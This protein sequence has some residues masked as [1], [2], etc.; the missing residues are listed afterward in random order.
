MKFYT[1]LEQFEVVPVFTNGYFFFSNS[2]LYLI[3][4]TVLIVLTFLTAL[5]KVEIIPSSW[6]SGIE[7]LYEFIISMIKQQAGRNALKFFPLVFLVFIFV[8]FSNLI[9][10][11]P[12]SFTTTAQ[13]IVTLTLAFS[14]N[15]GLIFFG[16]FAHGYKFLTLFVPSGLPVFLMPLVVVIEVVSYL[17][18]TFSLSIRLF[19][20]MMAGHTLLYILSSFAIGFLKSSFFILSIVPFVMVCAVLALELGIAM[21]QAYVFAVLFCIYL[22]DSLN[23]H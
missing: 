1:P 21:L 22:N 19:A 2:S 3:I 20:N 18:R 10:L 15:L 5:K 16:F 4:T 14:I 13:L 8:L 6:Q 12:L 23:L 9:G 7:V 17:L 11:I